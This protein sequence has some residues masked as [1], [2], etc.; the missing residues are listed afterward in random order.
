MSYSVN[1]SY[2]WQEL[3]R[4]EWD[5]LLTV[6][7]ESEEF[8]DGHSLT[9]AEITNDNDISGGEIESFLD[10]N[11]D[12]ELTVRDFRYFN[13]RVLNE[14]EAA[15][16]KYNYGL[17]MHCHLSRINSN[18]I[19]AV[20]A[21][22]WS[23]PGFVLQMISYEL[24]QP[25][26]DN[27][28]ENYPLQY[29]SE[30]LRRNRDF[31]FAVVR[32]DPRMIQYVS[33]DILD[34]DF[35]LQLIK[36]YPRTFEIIPENFRGDP[37]IVLEAI[38]YHYNSDL[39]EL[40]S[41]TLRGDPTFVLEAAKL[42]NKVLKYASQDLWEN[43]D[44]V[45]EA[46]KQNSLAILHYAPESL[47]NNREFVLEM[48]RQVAGLPEMTADEVANNR[49]AIL[50][51]VQQY[52]ILLRYASDDLKKD[53]ELV[54]AAVSQDFRAIVYASEELRTKY[55]VV[56]IALTTNLPQ[57][58]EI[59]L[60]NWR[61]ETRRNEEGQIKWRIQRLFTEYPELQS[62][63]KFINII[64]NFDEDGFRYASDELKSDRD[65]VLHAVAVSWQSYDYASDDL[66]RDLEIITEVA[67]Q[68]RHFTVMQSVPQDLRQRAWES[69]LAR[70]EE[71]GYV[72]PD[73][74]KNYSRF[75]ARI[76][77]LGINEPERIP[78][79]GIATVVANREVDR[80]DTRPIALMIYAKAMEREIGFGE[81]HDVVNSGIFRV[82][83]YE[84]GTDDEALEIIR[85][86]LHDYGR[87]I[88]TLWLSGHGTKM[89]L[90]L[91]GG[92]INAFTE[93]PYA[94]HERRFIDP[95]DLAF[96]L[97]DLIREAI[98][99]NG[100]VVLPSC[101]TGDGGEEGYNLTN[102]FARFLP[103]GVRLLSFSTDT[104][105]ADLDINSDGVMTLT[106]T[107]QNPPYVTHGRWGVTLANIDAIRGLFHD[108]YPDM[109]QEA[110]DDYF[111]L[112][113]QSPR[114]EY[115]QKIRE[116]L[117]DT[118][119]EVRNYAFNK[120]LNEVGTGLEMAD[121]V[122]DSPFSDTRLAGLN[123]YMEAL[124]LIIYHNS[125]DQVNWNGRLGAFE[126]LLNDSD[127][128]VRFFALETCKVLIGS[129]PAEAWAGNL[130]VIEIL[131][132]VSDPRLHQ[133][134]VRICWGLNRLFPAEVQD[135]HPRIM[136][137]LFDDLAERI[138]NQNRLLQAAQTP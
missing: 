97:G 64:M 101:S 107:D 6:L 33:E 110:M 77:E 22:F 88:H 76:D 130:G 109:R 55:D 62:D 11:R 45:L 111:S 32:I 89:T 117:S 108:P 43:E 118:L 119:A 60:F 103:R 112:I 122:A 94:G 21:P 49:E 104:S 35:I 75:V 135:G 17:M 70:L 54:I 134:V 52:G 23:N 68:G 16:K 132:G 41:E 86:V 5:S 51:A 25:Y 39:F 90:N 57:P 78:I 87:Q 73:A 81:I 85:N 138:E 36:L 115:L 128:D 72:A 53:E 133:E 1:V 47:Q 124:D 131:L 26:E 99:P 37:D 61:E 38:K 20:P 74:M 98:A 120:Y 63:R 126:R 50:K 34:K 27:P 30:D 69:F 93:M 102:T 42:N 100:Q 96:G 84:A 58:Y 3:S 18:N 10:R 106:Q 13:S 129:L 91:G 80:V 113:S 29:A 4:E 79:D 40:A 48:I 19:R 56:S 24:Y 137:A 114:D 116:L 95:S 127:E 12:G 136:E 7:N 15:L 121:A 9:A 71:L 44:F 125:L 65:T 105:V 66:K 83:Y 14:L 123:A 2:N 8:L 92:F 67:I 46:V 59:D 28:G 31:M 82:L